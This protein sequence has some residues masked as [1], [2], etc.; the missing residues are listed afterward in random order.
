MK[1]LSKIK[2]QDAVVLE[3]DEMK[4]IYG[5]SGSSLCDKRTSCKTTSDCGSGQIC[6][7]SD[8]KKCCY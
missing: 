4:I 6:I 2:L 8:G 3:N 5:G 7:T 1:E